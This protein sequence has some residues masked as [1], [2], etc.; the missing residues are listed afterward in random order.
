MTQLRRIEHMNHSVFR[1]L[2]QFIL[3]ACFVISLP[4]FVP[5]QDKAAENKGALTDKERAEAV[6]YFEETRQNFLDAIKGLSEAQWKYKAG[7]DRW[8]IAEVAEHIAVSEETIFNLV[9]MRLMQTPAAPEKKEAAKGKEALIRS[10]V[11]NR[12]VKA[13]APEML[14]PSNRWATHEE[15][16]KAF[17][18]SRDKTISYIKETKEDLRSHFYEH[19]VFKD[20]DAYQWLIFT[21]GHSARHTA[22]IN[23]VKEDPGYPKK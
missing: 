2:R 12:S 22:Q 4:G 11:T 10:S 9:T 3:P 6:K 13:Q 14:K 1:I 16:V 8:S 20:L 5:A 23:E 18:A 21:S 17:N 19:P 15:L 7:P